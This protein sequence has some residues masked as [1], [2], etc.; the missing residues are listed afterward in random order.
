MRALV[1]DDDDLVRSSLARI[2]TSMHVEVSQAGDGFAAIGKIESAPE[3]FDVI[4]CDLEMPGRDGVQTLRDM[5]ERKVT[6][7]LV[8]LSGHTRDIL[9]SAENTARHHSLYVLG[10]LNKPFDRAKISGF[11]EAVNRPRA[12]QHAAA[13]MGQHSAL[14]EADLCQG[15]ARGE[16]TLAFQPKVHPASGAVG[17][18]EALVRWTHTQYGPLPPVEFIALAEETALIDQLTDV[19]MR[20]AVAAHHHLRDAGHNIPIAVNLST[21]SMSHLDLADRLHALVVDGK[22]S[23]DGFIFEV[24]ESR[25]ADSMAAFLETATRLRLKGF[26]LSIDDF[27]TGFS[28]MEQVS[29]LPISE[30]KIDRAFVAGAP[31]NPRTRHILEASLQ[32]GH[33]LNLKCVCEGVE[34]R[35]EWELVQTLGTDAV[36]GYYVAQPMNISRLIPWVKDWPREWSD[37]KFQSSV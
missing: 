35:D 7:G 20:T 8:L 5:A 12:L 3:P 15:L 14:H 4:F 33:S 37:R 30:L 16:F 10:H 32:L 19:V 28:T 34:T 13:A 23:P 18:L 2:L 11:I 6:S 22:A 25:L 17:G 31:A 9:E 27:G 24:T 26:K 36:Q 21:R 29:R 1:I